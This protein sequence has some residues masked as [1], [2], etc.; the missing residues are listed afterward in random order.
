MLITRL[1]RLRFH[2]TESW[3]VFLRS[4]R[5]ILLKNGCPYDFLSEALALETA[6]RKLADHLS[7]QAADLR[8]FARAVAAGAGTIQLEK[9]IRD[10][11]LR[12]VELHQQFEQAAL[13][14]PTPGGE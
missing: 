12:R 6:A 3:P 9:H 1:R 2:G 10:L 14:L 11:E 4:D 7:S 5:Y 8:E 13:D